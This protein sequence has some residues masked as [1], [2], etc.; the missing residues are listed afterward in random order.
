MCACVKHHM[1]WLVYLWFRYLK[2]C[3]SNFDRLIGVLFLE[4]Y[5]L[6]V[7]ITWFKGRFAFS[8]IT[9]NISKYFV[10]VLKF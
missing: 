4:R 5:E 10:S 7:L 3:L 2:M 9:T 1:K 6:A 8:S